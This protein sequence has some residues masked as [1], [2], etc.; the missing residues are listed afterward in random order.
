MMK[1]SDL[2]TVNLTEYDLYEMSTFKSKY[3]GLP[4]NFEI[5]TRTDPLNH[6]HNRIKVTKDKEWAAI[7]TVGNNPKMVNNINY[8]ISERENS[9]L[10]DWI[11]ETYPIIINLIDGKIDTPDAAM[12]FSKLRG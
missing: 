5:W 8:S 12:E 9:M 4:D 2:V 10:L 3:T 11:R 1:I 6:G 7:Y